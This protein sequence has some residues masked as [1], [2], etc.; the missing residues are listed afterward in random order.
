MISVGT[1][2]SELGTK[3]GSNRNP[4]SLACHQ[5]RFFLVMLKCEAVGSLHRIFSCPT[6]R[7]D[8]TDP[9]FPGPMRCE[10]HVSR[11]RHRYALGVADCQPDG[12]QLWQSLCGN[13]KG[14]HVQQKEDQCLYQCL[15]PAKS[16]ILKLQM[17]DSDS[18]I[19]HGVISA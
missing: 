8:V 3:I 6:F 18:S 11:A 10:D 7:L 5:D 9:D 12:K 1:E 16:M 15:R 13:K 14:H 17:P 19:P 2:Y 4:A